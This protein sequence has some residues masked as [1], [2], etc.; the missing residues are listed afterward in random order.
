MNY[1]YLL[2]LIQ[3][4][5]SS[6]KHV[7]QFSRLGYFATFHHIET[8]TL[9]MFWDFV[10]D[11]SSQKDRT[12]LFNSFELFFLFYNY[13]VCGHRVCGSPFVPLLRLLPLIDSTRPSPLQLLRISQ[14]FGWVVSCKS[15]LLGSIKPYICQS[16][17]IF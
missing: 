10:I 17:Y 16:T 12:I 8:I 4:V 5:T 9:S 11:L 1:L 7:Q 13:E 6:S 15:K 2:F 3:N 14:D